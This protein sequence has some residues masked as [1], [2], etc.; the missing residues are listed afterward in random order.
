[1]YTVPP[2]RLLRLQD[3]LQSA[4]KEPLLHQILLFRSLHPQNNP[5]M[6]AKNFLLQIESFFP[7]PFLIDIRYNLILLM[8]C[9]KAFSYQYS[10]CSFSFLQRN[11][12][13]KYC[14]IMKACLF[15]FY[16]FPRS[17]LQNIRKKFLCV[18]FYGALFRH[19]T[20]IKINPFFFFTCK[21]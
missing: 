16:F 2:V 10:P 11:S 1:M 7:V 15:G 9:K 19:Y 8:F 14:H 6:H 13:F 18:F 3:L 20:T 12:L 5:Q 4:D 21:Y 17:N